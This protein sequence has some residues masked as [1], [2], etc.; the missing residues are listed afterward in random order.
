MHRSMK[1]LMFRVAT[2]HALPA[3]AVKIYTDKSE[4]SGY[5]PQTASATDNN[6]LTF[7]ANHFAAKTW[8]FRYCY[9]DLSLQVHKST[10]LR[11]FLVVCLEKTDVEMGYRKWTG[12]CNLVSL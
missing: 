4:N 3:S 5:L 10:Q 11:R 1:R 2:A 8:V 9:L 6:K 12:S 7:F